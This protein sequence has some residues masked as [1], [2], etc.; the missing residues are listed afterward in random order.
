MPTVNSAASFFFFAHD[1]GSD[2][3]VVAPLEKNEPPPLFPL[4]NALP[5]VENPAPPPPKIL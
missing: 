3:G 5:N 4:Q 2:D 1:F